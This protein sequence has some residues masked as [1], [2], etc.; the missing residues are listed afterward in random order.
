MEE[1]TRFCL[2]GKNGQLYVY[3]N[4]LVIKRKGLFGFLS[5]GFAGDK[6]IPFSTIQTVQIKDGSMLTNGYIQ[7]GILGAIERRGG[8]YNAIDDENAVVFTKSQNNLA[9]QIKDFIEEKIFNARNNTITPPPVPHSSA[10]EILKF[11]QLLDAGAINQEEF[12][13]KKKQI[14]GI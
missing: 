1:T 8:I 12:E 3:D 6:T 9:T 5:Q 10:D 2:K 11:K 13:A 14:L 4:R 7:F